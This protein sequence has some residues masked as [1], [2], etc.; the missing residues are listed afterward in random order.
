MDKRERIM[1]VYIAIKLYKNGQPEI[2]GVFADKRKAEEV[3]YTCK[4]GWGN[5]IEKEVQ[6]YV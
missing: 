4:G 3:A 2:L 5:V 6:G 1:K